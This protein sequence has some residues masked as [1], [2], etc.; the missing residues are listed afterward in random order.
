MRR[1]IADGA[2]MRSLEAGQNGRAMVD[3]ASI[4][5]HIQVPLEEGDI[6]LIAAA[7]AGH[8][9]AQT[10]LALKFLLAKQPKGALYWLE[11]AVKQDYAAAM[12]YL[13]RCYTDG[14]G[15]AKNENM[16]LIW[17]LKAAVAGHPIACAQMQQV[18]EKLA[19]AS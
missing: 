19:E 10:D 11:L 17:I 15:V 9:E 16:G 3:F 6:A 5:P 13:G 1:R 2:V 12:F 18:K 7:D 14:T 8:A 4:V